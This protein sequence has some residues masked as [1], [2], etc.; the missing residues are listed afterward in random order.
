MSE[1]VITHIQYT[2]V[3]NFVKNLYCEHLIKHIFRD[4]NIPVLLHRGILQSPFIR[5]YIK[6]YI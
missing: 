3:L 4:P 2:C 1:C 5:N 6:T